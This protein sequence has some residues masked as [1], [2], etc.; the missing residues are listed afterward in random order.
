MTNV[1][2]SVEWCRR[3]WQPES[4]DNYPFFSYERVELIYE[5]IM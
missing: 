4:Y 5:C 1:Q 3:L 2:V